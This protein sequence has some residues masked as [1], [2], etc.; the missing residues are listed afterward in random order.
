MLAWPTYKH[1]IKL[2][3]TNSFQEIKKFLQFY[4][5]YELESITAKSIYVYGQCVL[6]I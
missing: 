5:Y 2:K 1:H 3:S 6:S 4:N